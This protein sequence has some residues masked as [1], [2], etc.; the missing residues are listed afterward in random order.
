M[1]VH[2]ADVEA[3]AG[4]SHGTGAI[5]FMVA[6]TRGETR[7]RHPVPLVHTAVE[8]LLE[9]EPQLLGQVARKRYRAP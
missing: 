3:G 1:R 2:N 6:V 7:F 8:R 9:R 5:R 4:A